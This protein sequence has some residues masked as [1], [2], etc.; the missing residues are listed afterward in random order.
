MNF[1]EAKAVVRTTIKT[2][3]SIDDEQANREKSIRK[4]SKEVEKDQRNI[5][6]V[7]WNLSQSFS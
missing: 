4:E 5:Q 6:I 2:F 1:N 3:P 7:V